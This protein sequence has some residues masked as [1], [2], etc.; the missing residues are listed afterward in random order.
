MIRYYRGD[1]YPLMC[2]QER[3]LMVLACKFVDDLVIEAPFIITEDLIK[4]LNISKV[5][6]VVTDEDTVLPAH[7]EVDQFQVCRQM[8]ILHEIP[9]DKDE[10]TVE[11]IAQRV[12][13]DKQALTAKFE[14]K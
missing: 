14:R 3:L 8:G 13:M 2:L 10:L 7:K 9:R 11:K 1:N 6:S 5:V 4:S 12:Y